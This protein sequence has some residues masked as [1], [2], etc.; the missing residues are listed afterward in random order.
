MLGVD[1]D[2]DG[3]D[4]ED[5]D[6][7]SDD[8]GEDMEVIKDETD[9]NL[10][11]LRWMIYQT[12]MSSAGA[13]EAG[14]K[15]L[16]VVR[17]GQEVE[18]CGMLVECC[19]Q[20]RAS[21]ARFYGQ[22]GQRL[23]GVGRAYRAGFDA[24][25]ARCYAAAHRMGTDELRAAAGLFA[26]LL[27]ADAVPWRG[28]LGG[29]RITEEDPTSSSRI[30]MKVMFQEMVEQLGVRVLGRRMND[31]DNPVVRDALFPRDKAENTRFAI[32]FFM[33]IELGGVTEPARK[34]LSL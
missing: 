13:E 25:F 30:F 11:N 22:L 10:M 34:I 33:A 32:N 3:E 26:H 9:A 8:D 17:P 19:K 20:E 29:V 23:C 7:E 28:V 6:D 18:L 15:L 5:K 21:N 16:S 1:P 4:D 24:C 2:G 14:H 27:A 12:I 31:D